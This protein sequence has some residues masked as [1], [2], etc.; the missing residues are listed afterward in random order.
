MATRAGVEVA[1]EVVEETNLLAQIEADKRIMKMQ[2]I[3]VEEAVGEINHLVPVE[4]DNHRT[5]SREISPLGKA[6][7]AAEAADQEE[8]EKEETL[9]EG[10]TTT[11]TIEITIKTEEVE[12][13]EEEGLEITTQAEVGVDEDQ[14]MLNISSAGVSGEVLNF[15]RQLHKNLLKNSAPF[16][17]ASTDDCDM[18]KQCWAAA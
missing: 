2:Q 6:V 16:T 1:A 3:K 9:E 7:E 12:E 4:E 18:W 15:W 14:Q 8:E 10:I 11:I 5:E 13:A 17:T